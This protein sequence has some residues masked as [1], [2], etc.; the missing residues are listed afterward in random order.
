[1]EVGGNDIDAKCS[2]SSTNLHAVSHFDVFS[3]DFDLMTIEQAWGQLL[4]YLHKRH[5]ALTTY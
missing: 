2:G 1:V 5:K 3:A 4:L